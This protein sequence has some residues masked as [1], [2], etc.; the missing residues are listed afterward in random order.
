MG[1]THCEHGAWR[2]EGAQGTPLP[3][4]KVRPGLFSLPCKHFSQTLCLGKYSN[5]FTDGETKTQER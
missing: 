2:R 5:H 3:G 4:S 1:E